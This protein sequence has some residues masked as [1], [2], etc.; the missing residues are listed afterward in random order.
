MKTYFTAWVVAQTYGLAYKIAMTML[1]EGSLKH[2]CP[3]YSG[4]FRHGLIER[5]EENIPILFL[6]AGFP[7]DEQTNQ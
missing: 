3:L 1:M 7:G 5:I 4:E 2:A 6:D